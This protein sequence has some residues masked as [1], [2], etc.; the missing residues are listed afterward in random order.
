MMFTPIDEVPTGMSFLVRSFPFI[1]LRHLKVKSFFSIYKN[2]G[3][4]SARIHHHVA[5]QT[6][7]KRLRAISPEAMRD[8]GC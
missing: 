6:Q 4:F 2:S 5:K 3:H 1:A 7:E 8:P